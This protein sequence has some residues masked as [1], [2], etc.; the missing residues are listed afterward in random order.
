MTRARAALAAA[1]AALLA[2]ATLAAVRSV[3]ADEAPAAPLFKNVK[4]LTSVSSKAEMRQIM[5]KQAAS[6]GVKC[7]HCHVP[8][9]F[10]LDEKP[11]KETARRMMRMV[12]EINAKYFKEPDDPKVTCFTCHAGKEEPENEVPAT[13]LTSDGDTFEAAR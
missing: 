1:A 2:G 9:K 3:R 8:G 4:V 5:K 12:Q 13:L 10:D 11:E 7:A 6:L